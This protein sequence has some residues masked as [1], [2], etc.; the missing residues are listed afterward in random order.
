[1][2][3]L[4]VFAVLFFFLLMGAF[5]SP[6]I[7]GCLGVIIIFGILTAFFIF[8]SINFLWFVAAGVII[9]LIGFI[10]RFINWRKLPEVNQ[11]LSLHPQCKLD[12][13]VSCYNCGSSQLTHHGL[14]H[15]SSKLRFYTCS[16]CGTTLFRFKVL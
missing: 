12:M 1:M 4:E 2:Y 8:F 11:Y 15:K 13:G 14:L 5:F 7:G 16:D 6:I 9:Y 3:F 10:R